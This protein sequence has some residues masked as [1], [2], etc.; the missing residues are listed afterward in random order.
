MQVLVNTCRYLIE[1]RKRALFLLLS[2]VFSVIF[3]YLHYLDI[4]TFCFLFPHVL[5]IQLFFLLLQFKI[6]N[7]ILTLYIHFFQV[8]IPFN[9]SFLN[10]LDFI[11][12]IC[13]KS[14]FIFL[15]VPILFIVLVSPHSNLWTVCIKY[16]FL[17]ILDLTR[18]FIFEF[19]Y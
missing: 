15:P 11:K 1:N 3:L 6:L 9:S 17:S 18:Y 8:F 7:Y 16:I 14:I 2:D 19:Y 4:L 10:Q 12:L 13:F 5:T